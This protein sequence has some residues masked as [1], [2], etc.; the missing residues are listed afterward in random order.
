MF[1]LP[2]GQVSV[3]RH[4]RLS[5]VRR[6]TAKCGVAVGAAAFDGPEYDTM[7]EKSPAGVVSDGFSGL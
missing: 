7:F 1:G 4:D 3:G 6:S 5:D 2:H